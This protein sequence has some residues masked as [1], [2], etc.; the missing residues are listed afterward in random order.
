MSDRA[1]W[2]RHG[3]QWRAVIAV[4]VITGT[5]VCPGIA[6]FAE[7]EKAGDVGSRAV[8]DPKLMPSAGP[9]LKRPGVQEAVASGPQP[10][11]RVTQ[12]AE[13]FRPQ[14]VQV[15]ITAGG[16][17]LPGATF[18]LTAGN[19]RSSAPMVP[20]TLPDGTLGVTGLGIIIQGQP[21]IVPVNMVL[22][23]PSGQRQEAST[24]FEF[25]T[26]A[27]TPVAGPL[28]SWSRR[29]LDVGQRFVVL[30]EFRNEAVLDQETGLVWQLDATG[31]PLAWVETKR[32]LPWQHVIIFKRKAPGT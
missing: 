28:S 14:G 5:L 21:G 3:I 15:T 12:P 22:S 6:A 4:F 13:E 32:E 1:W 23:A 2:N 7:E 20:A 29:I 27:R 24:T 26:F 17:T 31:Q 19:F 18:N 11:V 10:W 8:G 9:L 16:F 30:T 25:R